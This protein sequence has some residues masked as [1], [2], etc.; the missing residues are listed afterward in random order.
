MVEVPEDT[1]VTMPLPVPT[2]ATPVVL[3]DHTPP[4]AVLLNVI[5]DPT[6]TADDPVIGAG[7]G[8]TVTTKVT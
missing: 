1:P 7:T 5:V 8:L 6:Q 4:P 2:V 3:L